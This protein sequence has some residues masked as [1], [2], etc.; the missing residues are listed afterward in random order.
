MIGAKVVHQ[1][2]LLVMD[3]SIAGHVKPDIT[4]HSVKIHVQA[5]LIIF[6]IK[7]PLPVQ[8]VV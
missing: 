2:V 6:V 8:A 3:T 4:A 7:I 1:H 5:V